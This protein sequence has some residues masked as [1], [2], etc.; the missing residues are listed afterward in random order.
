MLVEIWAKSLP[1]ASGGCGSSTDALS[2]RS[3]L[4]P[5]GPARS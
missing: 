5:A 3:L 2:I 1:P 4:C